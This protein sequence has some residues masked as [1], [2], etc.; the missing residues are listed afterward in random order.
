MR[1]RRFGSNALPEILRGGRLAVARGGDDG[2]DGIARS[3][4]QPRLQARG[5]IKRVQMRIG[6]HEKPS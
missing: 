5:K 2:R 3:G 1:V 6:V 4:F